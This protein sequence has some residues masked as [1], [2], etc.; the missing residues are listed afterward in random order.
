MHPASNH[1]PSPD[2]TASLLVAALEHAWQT[3]RQRHPD[4][5]QAVLVVASG[6]EGKRLNLGDLQHLLALNLRQCPRLRP[7]RRAGWTRRRRR[8]AVRPVPARAGL[9]QRTARGSGAHDR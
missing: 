7:C 2:G 4:V 6:G 1:S 8:A 3:I 5:P 9:A